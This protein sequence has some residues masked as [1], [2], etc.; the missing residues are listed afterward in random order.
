MTILTM[1]FFQM[2]Q[3]LNTYFVGHLKDPDILAGIGLGNMLLNMFVFAISNGMNGTIESFVGWSYG[4][5]RYGECGL[6]LNR[7][8][9]MILVIM[10]PVIITF[11]Y[12]DTIL[13][14]LA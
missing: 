4:S 13:I 7:A 5:Q 14:A 6:H 9:I 12:V 1:I 8:R 2:V 3:F 11:F 10:I